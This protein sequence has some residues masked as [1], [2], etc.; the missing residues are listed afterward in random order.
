MASLRIFHWQ[1]S[2]KDGKQGREV[3]KGNSVGDSNMES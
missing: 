1:V 3:G 2:H